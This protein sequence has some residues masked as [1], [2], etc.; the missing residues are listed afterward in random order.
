MFMMC[1]CN[2]LVM[3]VV[4]LWSGPALSANP[5]QS[6]AGGES[7]SP[8]YLQEMRYLDTNR[9]RRIDAQEFAYGQQM[10]SMLLMFSWEEAD[11]DGDG[12][13]SHSEFISAADE[14]MQALLETETD[15]DTEADQQAE[16]D[17]ASAISLP[18]LL[19]QL[20]ENDDYADELADLRAAVEDLDD[21]EAVVTHIL[22][23]SKRYSHLSPVVRTWVRHYPVRPALRRHVKPAHPLAPK[24]RV[25][26]KSVH[27]PGP[28]KKKTTT[29]KKPAKKPAPKPKHKP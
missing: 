26:P 4:C 13:L 24:H 18:V 2:W 3:P 14:A 21:D 29:P 6:P 28:V 17:L 16:E 22:H 9:D 5:P 23:N 25:K 27:K 7:K 8:S 20:S 15:T 1:L 19:N 10:A 12:V 11:R